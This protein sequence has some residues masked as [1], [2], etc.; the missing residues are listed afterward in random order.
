VALANLRDIPGLLEVPVI[1]AD[2]RYHFTPILDRS[3]RA[4]GN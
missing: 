4:F 2:A 3:R 1:A